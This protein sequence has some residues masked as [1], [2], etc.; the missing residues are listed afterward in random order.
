MLLAQVCARVCMCV[1]KLIIKVLA[2]FKIFSG[3]HGF[4][5]HY[6]FNLTECQVC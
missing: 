1:R 4:N 2:I 5:I 3:L 6:S